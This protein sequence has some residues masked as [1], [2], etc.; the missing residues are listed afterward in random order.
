MCPEHWKRRAPD[1]CQR[2]DDAG[3]QHREPL[4]WFGSGAVGGDGELAAVVHL[5][6]Q[7]SV[8]DERDSQPDYRSG[9]G[10]H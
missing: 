7:D 8:G 1:G 2:V 5:A 9:C 3:G 6:K 10:G 4:R